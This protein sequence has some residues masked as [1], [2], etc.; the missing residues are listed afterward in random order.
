MKIRLILVVNHHPPVILILI[1]DNLCKQEI[2]CTDMVQRWILNHVQILQAG[3]F[4]CDLDADGYN[5]LA[6]GVPNA[7]GG[8]G[9]IIYTGD[10][11]SHL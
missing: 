9:R 11:W 2:F 4:I 5:D 3:I 8:L 1:Q 7:A 10:D 6:V